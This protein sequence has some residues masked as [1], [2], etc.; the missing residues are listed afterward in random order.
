MEG[1]KGMKT[2]TN[3][4]GRPRKYPINGVSPQWPSKEWTGFWR[5]QS[6]N[7]LVGELSRMNEGF[8]NV[9]N[10][11]REM[12]SSFECAENSIR[13]GLEGR[14]GIEEVTSILDLFD[15][16]IRDD[17]GVGSFVYQDRVHEARAILAVANARRNTDRKLKEKGG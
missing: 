9:L 12:K 1:K 14:V 6:K 15:R 8:A 5:L 11:V 4:R 17:A 13:L 7:T 3:K 2:P 16:I 10:K